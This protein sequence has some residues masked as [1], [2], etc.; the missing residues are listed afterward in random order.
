MI[1]DEIKV[2]QIV[3]ENYILASIEQFEKET[4]VRIK[5]L[6]LIR[7]KFEVSCGYEYDDTLDISY[8]KIV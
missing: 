1:S 7:T 4:G 3:M 8:E 2:K 5:E 6:S